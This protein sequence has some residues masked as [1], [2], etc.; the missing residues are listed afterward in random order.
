MLYGHIGFD[1]FGEHIYPGDK[2]KKL[3]DFGNKTAPEY[4]AERRVDDNIV[5]SLDG[6]EK[7]ID[8]NELVCL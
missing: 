5:V 8:E 6:V 1:N 7:K 3:T 4:T 2:V